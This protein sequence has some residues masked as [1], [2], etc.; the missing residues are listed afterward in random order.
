MQDHWLHYAQFK[1]LVDHE[2]VGR[3]GDRIAAHVHHAF[4]QAEAHIDGGLVHVLARAVDSLERHLQ[5]REVGLHG[6][7]IP[8]LVPV[9]EIEAALVGMAG[10]GQAAVVLREVGG[11]NDKPWILLDPLQ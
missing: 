10:V 9:G 6:P 8:V 2:L 7:L 1:G 3:Q 5:R 4:T 11:E